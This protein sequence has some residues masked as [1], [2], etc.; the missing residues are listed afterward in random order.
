MT[1]EEKWFQHLAPDEKD[2]L[3]SILQQQEGEEQ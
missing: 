3:N 2:H 1:P